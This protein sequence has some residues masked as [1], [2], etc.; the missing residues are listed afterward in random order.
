MTLDD[1]LVREV[2]KLAKKMHTNRSALTR[3]ALYEII[4]R[5][6][7]QNMEARHRAGYQRNPVKPKEFSIWEEEQSWGD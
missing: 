2:D 3:R 4:E 5:T 7:A 1:D 6:N